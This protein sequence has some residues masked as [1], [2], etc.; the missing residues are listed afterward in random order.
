[1]DTLRSSTESVAEPLENMVPFMPPGKTMTVR[2]GGCT[3]QR[4]WTPASRRNLVTRGAANAER[5]DA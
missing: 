3:N 1:M 4:G 5:R 2:C